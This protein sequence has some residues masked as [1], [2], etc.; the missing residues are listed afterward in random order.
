M[1]ALT[2]S[3]LYKGLAVICC[4]ASACGWILLIGH[5]DWHDMEAPRFW[6]AVVRVAHR[7]Q[8]CA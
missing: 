2:V 5:E 6:L 8:R 7:S 3:V 4:T 1:P